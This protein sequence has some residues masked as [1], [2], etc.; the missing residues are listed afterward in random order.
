MLPLVAGCAGGLSHEVKKQV[1]FSG[2]FEMLAANP[3]AYI[4][5]V[6]LLGGRI[7]EVKV[8]TTSS[9]VIVLQH[10]LDVSSD[11][12]KSEKG[13]QGRFIL[14]SSE[15]LDPEIYRTSY[16]ISVAGRVTGK[17]E[18]KVGEFTMTLPRIEPIE[19]K[20]WAP[21]AASSYPHVTFWFG[22]GTHF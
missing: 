1:S 9:E 4:G 17:A 8:E 10:P 16:L 19:V 7:L 3:E 2:S 18:Q 11:R 22:V 14:Q 6:A 20:L 15:F 13:S 21:Q 12:P 5:E